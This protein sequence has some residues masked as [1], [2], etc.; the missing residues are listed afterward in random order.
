MD[1]LASFKWCLSRQRELT[2][3][4]CRLLSWIA[5]HVLLEE[6]EVVVAADEIDSTWTEDS[7]HDHWLLHPVETFHEA[8]SPTSC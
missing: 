7:E 8:I 6:L 5:E 2:Q 4:L 3:A 1:L